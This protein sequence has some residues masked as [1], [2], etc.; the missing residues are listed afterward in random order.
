[1]VNAQLGAAL[2]DY[3]RLSPLEHTAL[4]MASRGDLTESEQTAKEIEAQKK[5]ATE[6]TA[7][8]G[9]PKKPQ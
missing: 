4:A 6:L 8:F 7:A 2:L 3:W 5:L 9:P 1:V